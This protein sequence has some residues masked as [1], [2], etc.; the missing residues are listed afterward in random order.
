MAQIPELLQDIKVCSK[1]IMFLG[2][3]HYGS[4][5]A[6]DLHYAQAVWSLVTAG[7]A[8]EVTKEIQTFSN[9]IEDINDAF[10]H[11]IKSLSMFCFYE[12]VEMR[13]PSLKKIVKSEFVYFDLFLAKRLFTDNDRL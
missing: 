9:T 13:L 12:G 11:L 7:T 8:S 1:G 6:G 4:D 2:T 10:G 3:P 5:H